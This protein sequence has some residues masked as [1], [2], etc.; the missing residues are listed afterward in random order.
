MLTFMVH[1]YTWQCTEQKIETVDV[2]FS[3]LVP[4]CLQCN[5]AAY[6]MVIPIFV[7]EILN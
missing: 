3:V 7:I 5:R 6:Q 1:E 2:D 4:N